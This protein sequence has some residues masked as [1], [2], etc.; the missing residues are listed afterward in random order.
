MEVEDDDSSI[1]IQSNAFLVVDSNSFASYTDVSYTD[2]LSPF[3]PGDF[4]GFVLA[5]D[6]D[7]DPEEGLERPDE[8]PNY[9]GQVRVLGS[10]VWGDVFALLETQSSA[11]DDFWPLAM[12]HPNEVYV[13]P[14]VPSQV[15]KWN[16]PNIDRW[17]KLR[18]VVDPKHFNLKR[19]DNGLPDF[20]SDDDL[21]GFGE[22]A[23]DAS[24]DSLR[25]VMLS[26]FQ[27]Y[28][29]N[30][31][32][33]AQAAAIEELKDIGPSGTPDPQ[34]VQQRIQEDEELRAQQ[35]V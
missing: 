26:S 32:Q 3:L 2:A 29:V 28:L 8:S 13:G 22:V 15:E 18:G 19:G 30:K 7:F 4:A 6:P 34:R 14:T 11:L 10:L 33:H 21:K 20:I 1:V 31:G 23:G 25:D 5:V 16:S 9:T 24:V 35:N 17:K 27:E 12:K